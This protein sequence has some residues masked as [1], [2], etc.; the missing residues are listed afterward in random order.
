MTIEKTKLND[1]IKEIYLWWK[2]M[3]G[4]GIAKSSEQ[5]MY[6]LRRAHNI[7]ELSLQDCVYGLMARVGAR[8]NELEKYALI[9]GVLAFV[10]NNVREDG[11]GKRISFAASLGSGR[12]GQCLFS[13]QRMASLIASTRHL[14]QKDSIL[15]QFRRAVTILDGNVNVQDLI[16]GLLD[17][18]DVYRADKRRA[19]WNYDYYFNASVK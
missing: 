19:S 5:E 4:S 1:T 9:A 17:L 6:L 16:G 2:F 10:K 12:G 15:S 13:E 11:D 8:K 7:S 3:S 18:T 14:R